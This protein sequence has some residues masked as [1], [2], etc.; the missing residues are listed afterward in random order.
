MIITPTYIN[1]L[2]RFKLAKQIRTEASMGGGAAT[3]YRELHLHKQGTPN[4]GGGMI[5]IVVGIMVAATV[6]VE[7]LQE[8]LGLDIRY[9][10][11]NR[12]ETFLPLFAIFSMGIL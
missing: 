7:P 10:L 1:L 2:R 4:M 5:L 9:T 11:W 6:I 8:P 12:A 3:K